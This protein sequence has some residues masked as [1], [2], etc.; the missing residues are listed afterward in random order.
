MSLPLPPPLPPPRAAEATTRGVH[1]D[2]LVHRALD[3][4]GT[5]VA[6]LGLDGSIRHLNR[7]MLDLLGVSTL[8]DVAAGSAAAGVLRSF[9]DQLPSDVFRGPRSTWNG[10]VD[11][12]ALSGRQMVLRATA[13]VDPTSGPGDVALLLHDVTEAQAELAELFRRASCD[14]LTGLIDRP[15]V[16]EHLADALSTQGNS[17]AHVAAILVDIDKF[18]HINEVFGPDIGDEL[19]VACSKRLVDAL[20]PDDEVA[21]LGG[22]EFL[23]VADGVSDS[24]AAVELAERAGRALTGRLRVGDVDLDLSVSVGV[25]VTERRPDLS[26]DQ[27]ASQ[28]IGNAETAADHAKRSGGSRCSIFTSQMRSTARERAELAVELSRS[29][30]AGRLEVEYQPI[31]SAVSRRAVGAEALVRWNHPTRGRVDPDTFIAVAEE[32][33]SIGRL[34]ELVLER[35]LA[36][37]AEWLHEQRVDDDFVVHVNVSRTQLAS[38]SYVGSVAARLNAHGI[39]PHRLVLEARE[40]PLLSSQPGVVRTIRALRRLGVRLAIDDFGTGARSLAV[41]TDV[42]ADVLKLDGSLA[43]PSG[44]SLAEIRVVRAVVALA[45]ALDIDVVAER[46]DG[47]EQLERLQAAGC[48]MLQGNLL[49][50][51]CR[52]NTARFHPTALW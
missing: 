52:P 26:P 20:R 23:V 7:P 1:A 29:I 5:A 44:S 27:V 16:L 13:S 18:A 46:V 34:G 31:Y 28:L 37:F 42:G 40:T 12:R 14:R 24:V 4:D 47:P 38:P 21:R 15:T 22:D 10:R 36:D 49:G 25:A 8:A 19:L 39:D 11:H 48:D 9:L 35:A 33:G 3:D 41:L 51:P 45:H 6:L 43:L 30:A 32:A 17:P 2:R 50:A